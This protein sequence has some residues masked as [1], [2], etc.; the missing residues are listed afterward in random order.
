M[1][2]IR[3]KLGLRSFTLIELL[4]VIAIIAIL[5]ALLLPAVAKARKRAKMM[6]TL[7]NGRGLFTLL[8]ADDMEKFAQ[9]ERSPFPRTVDNYQD[10]TEYFKAKVEDGTL[11]VAFSFFAAPG[12]DPATGTTF[13]A[14]NNAWCMTLD[15]TDNNRAQT[16]VLFTRNVRLNGN[17]TGGDAELVEDRDPFGDSGCIVVYLGGGASTLSK[18]GISNKFN[19]GGQS[20]G[21]LRAGTY[22]E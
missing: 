19:P 1:K 18:A 20:N 6:Q 3:R 10:S 2:S 12:V 11:N 9:G 17:D 15:I 21:V 7:N 16:P 14:A 8:F 13:N 22:Q 4:V 5:A